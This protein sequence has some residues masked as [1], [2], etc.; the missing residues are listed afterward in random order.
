MISFLESKSIDHNHHSSRK[1]NLAIIR[2]D[3]QHSLETLLLIAVKEDSSVKSSLREKKLK[4][5][6]NFIKKIKIYKKKKFQV[7][8]K[9]LS[10]EMIKNNH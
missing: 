3:Y 1:K 2:D 4:K 5:L 6:K 7:L 10:L 9:Q 8:K